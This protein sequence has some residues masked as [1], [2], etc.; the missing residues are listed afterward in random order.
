MRTPDTAGSPRCEGSRRARHG[1][2]TKRERI[3][4]S[5]RGCK[6]KNAGADCK[7][8][9]HRREHGDQVHRASQCLRGESAEQGVA[10]EPPAEAHQQGE[11]HHADK[12]PVPCVVRG[13]AQR[14]NDGVDRHCHYRQPKRC[15]RREVRKVRHRVRGGGVIGA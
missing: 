4:Q 2:E 13:A 5:H 3:E 1:E 15:V 12:V 6:P 9:R 10:D 14:S 7:Y 8:D 11:N